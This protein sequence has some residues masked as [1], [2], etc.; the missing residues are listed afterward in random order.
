MDCSADSDLE[1]VRARHSAG[2]G[3]ESGA[4]SSVGQV[5]HHVC[6]EPWRGLGLLSPGT[7]DD[8][9]DT[10]SVPARPDDAGPAGCRL[11]SRPLCRAHPQA[12]RLPAPP[13]VR[14]DPLQGIQRAHL[15]P[16]IRDLDQT[17]LMAS[18][19]NTMMHALHCLFPVC[20]HRR[21]DRRRPRGV[22]PAP[23]DPWRR[24]THPRAGPA[25]G[26]SRRPTHHRALRPSTR[27]P[28]PPQRPLP[29]RLR[30]RRL[31]HPSRGPF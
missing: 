22:R 8:R 27:K 4:R 21:P 9:Y 11:L 2:T 1:S 15:E 6:G 23:Q 26:P 31:T 24:V 12:V 25:R 16:Y 7:C 20:A 30:G 19:V 17:G 3:S 13:L 28:R 18:S 10:A 14:L 5:P 29:H